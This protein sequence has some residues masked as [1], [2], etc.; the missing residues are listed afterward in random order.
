MLTRSI[1]AIVL[2]L[3]CAAAQS[4]APPDQPS[5]PS[6]PEAQNTAFPKPSAPVPSVQGVTST[7]KLDYTRSAPAFPNIVAPY[8]PRHVP[9]PNMNNSTRTLQLLRD[10][11][12]YISIDDAVALALENNL[13]L[14][15]ARYNLL[16]ADTDLLR[17][18]AGA[19]PRGV[20]SG[21]VQGTA[22]GG[23]G[24]IGAGTA[25]GGAGGTAQGSGGAGAGASGLVQ[26]T[27]GA[28][29]NVD[30]YDPT[31]SAQLN[32]EHAVYP[33]SN[34]VT[35]GV[36]SVGQNTTNANFEYSQS[37]LTGTNLQVIF[38]N[39]RQTSTAI[40]NTL[41]PY[42]S[43]YYR[44]QIRQHLLSGFGI[45]PNIR[46]IRIAKNNRE[47]TDIAFRDQV[48]AT[49]SQIENLY[50]DLVNAYEDERVKQRA[51]DLA[52]K[53]LS[54]DKEQVKI[55]NLAPFEVTRAEAEVASRNQDLI[56]S[57]TTLQLQQ[58]LMKNAVTRSLNDPVLADAVVIPTDTM[59][60]PQQEPVVPV[61]DLVADAMHNRADL[62][63]AR[64][65]MTNREISKKSAANNL[66]PQVDAVAFYGGSGLAGAPNTL[67]PGFVPGSITPTGLL[68]SWSGLGNSPD[69]YVGLQ[70]TIPIRNRVAQADQIR[71]ELEYRQAEMR[72]QQ[73]QN[74]IAIEV[75]NAQFAVQQDR[76]QVDAARKSR[77]LA[78]HS[79][80]IEQQKMN[81]GASTSNLVLTAQRD[82]AVAE[83]TLVAAMTKYEK[84]RVDLDRLT[85]STL[86]HLGI[87]IGDA[88]S[89]KVQHMPKVPGVASRPQSET[90]A[91]TKQ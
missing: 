45:G 19:Q 47:T 34:T 66:L 1:I 44:V 81:L 18:K 30:S 7:Q 14:G 88:E 69:Y 42:L 58:L 8:M 73:L 79:L 84:G 46:F 25:G 62:A 87:E 61:Q 3:G 32:V 13:D 29:S 63:Q 90:G 65:D 64:I 2:M 48:T 36:P 6:A 70:V 37:F 33:L 39:G 52:S 12:L 67:M 27:L 21:L 31:L 57:Q 35:L 16:I 91:E 83:S 56:L 10:G 38:Q 77:D 49:V 50:W 74:Q 15:I 22:G 43:N 75:R 82:L 80:E 76:A 5:T 11:K 85:G 23:V 68:D 20:N 60:I 51:L 4:S 9:P 59:D 78:Q 17:T 40:F 71:S 72:L 55:G 24:G 41:N 26:S 86:Q 53:T 54:D 28:G 89:G